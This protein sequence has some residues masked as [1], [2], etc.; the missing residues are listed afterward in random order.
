[1]TR[2][3]RTLPAPPN[4][5]S[6]SQGRLAPGAPGARR[7]RSSHAAPWPG[8]RPAMRPNRRERPLAV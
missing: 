5:D 8:P 6:R 3:Q 4:P 2:R 1:M 7:R